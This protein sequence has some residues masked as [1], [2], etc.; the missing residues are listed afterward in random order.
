LHVKQV[1]SSFLLKKWT[2]ELSSGQEIGIKQW[3]K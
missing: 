1:I 2:N 3:D